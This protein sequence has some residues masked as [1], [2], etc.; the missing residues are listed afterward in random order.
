MASLN[1]LLNPQNTALHADRY[2]QTYETY[3]TRGTYTP[4]I[5]TCTHRDPAPLSAQSDSLSTSPSPERDIESTN[6]VDRAESSE[7]TY[8]Q[9][10][11]LSRNHPKH[12]NCPDTLDCLPDTDGRPQHTLPVILRCA[13]LGSPKQRLTIRE[14]YSAMEKKYAYYTT[15]GPAWKVS[16]RLLIIR[17]GT[18][19]F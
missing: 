9:N 12:D 11:S 6:D 2:A 19:A 13:I 1:T 3:G 4:L 17:K 16:E 8:Y 18:W 15:A 14:I 7:P 5:T 10:D